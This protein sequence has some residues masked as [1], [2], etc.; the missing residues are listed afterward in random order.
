MLVK[1]IKVITGLTYVIKEQLM[2]ILRERWYVKEKNRK[3][4]SFPKRSE[5]EFQSAS[6]LLFILSFRPPPSCLLFSSF[7][8]ILLIFPHLAKGGW[9]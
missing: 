7:G 2:V 6:K 3:C 4:S 1:L 8:A 9:V 5:N